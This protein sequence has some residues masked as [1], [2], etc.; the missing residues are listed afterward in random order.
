MRLPVSR[1][2]R[3]A[4]ISASRLIK[5]ATL[6]T[7]AQRSFIDHDAY[8]PESKDSRAALIASRVSAAV[9][10]ETIATTELSCG[11]L[12]SRTAPSDD[13]THAPFI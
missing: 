2:S 9:A 8:T 5:S 10:S 1:V 3:E 6:L 13:A 4:R 12:I 11:L 7:S